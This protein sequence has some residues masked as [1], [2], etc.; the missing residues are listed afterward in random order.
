MWSGSPSLQG[1]AVRLVP[2]IEQLMH[3][4]MRIPALCR[5]SYRIATRTMLCLRIAHTFRGLT[6]D[7][8]LHAQYGMLR[9]FSE[10]QD[11]CSTEDATGT[12]ANGA[13]ERLI[14]WNDV[15]SVMCWLIQASIGMLAYS[16]APGVES[17]ARMQAGCAKIVAAPVPALRPCMASH[18]GPARRNAERFWRNVA[19]TSSR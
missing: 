15:P 12:P 9:S 1:C 8:G 7:S 6:R 17:S 10:A 18:A 11:R 5:V 16:I 13:R 4:R 2:L 3:M 14:F 19:G